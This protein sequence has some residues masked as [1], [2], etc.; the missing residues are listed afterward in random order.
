MNSFQVFVIENPAQQ[1]RRADARREYSQA[2]RD[3]PVT[4]ELLL[5]KMRDSVGHSVGKWLSIIREPGLR[6]ESIPRTVPGQ[7]EVR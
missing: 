4:H 5:R 6:A 7:A 1:R 3:G 2:D